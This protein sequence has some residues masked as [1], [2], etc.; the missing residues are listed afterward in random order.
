[1]LAHLKMAKCLHKRNDDK[2]VFFCQNL[3]L[4]D[5]KNTKQDFKEFLFNSTFKKVHHLITEC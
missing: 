2:I 3:K 4:L 1:M 5:L